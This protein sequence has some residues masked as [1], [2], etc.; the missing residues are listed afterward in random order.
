LVGGRN[1][2]TGIIPVQ[3]E[4]KDGNSDNNHLSNLEILCASCHSLTPTFGALN[5]GNGRA[6]RRDKRREKILQEQNV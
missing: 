4:H 3:L 1:T 5:K 6:Q 2:T